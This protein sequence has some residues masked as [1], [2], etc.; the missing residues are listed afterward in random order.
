MLTN[1][2]I[3]S[4]CQ[5]HKIELDCVEMKDELPKYRCNNMIIN[6]E[7]SSEGN[8]THWTA[9]LADKNEYFFFDSF[10]G[11]PSTEITK[12]VKQF[13]PKS[14][15]FNNFIIQNLN[16]EMCGWFCIALLHYVQNNKG[17]FYD[18]INDFINMFDSN[19]KMNDNIL[20]SIIKNI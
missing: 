7:S 16:S 2:K 12:Y 18:K 8:G 17:T 19:T 20:K 10:G 1:F 5:K 14:Y 4:Y 13:K 15:G 9:L 11:Y 3:I 6:L